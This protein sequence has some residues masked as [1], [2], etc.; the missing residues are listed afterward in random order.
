M[1]CGFEEVKHGG[2]RS[3]WVVHMPENIRVPRK[4]LVARGTLTV[5]RGRRGHCWP[6]N[7]DDGDV[8]ASDRTLSTF[9]P[10]QPGKHECAAWATLL[11][12]SLRCCR[13]HHY[14]RRRLSLLRNCAALRRRSQY[15]FNQFRP[16]LANTE[17]ATRANGSICQLNRARCNCQPDPYRSTVAARNASH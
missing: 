15:V 17:A 2:T 8:A 14:C 12:L 9:S 13:P 1:V 7:E 10:T 16:Y 4:P 5:E 3:P 11:C 6:S